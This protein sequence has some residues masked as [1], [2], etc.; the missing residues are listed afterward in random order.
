MS[1]RGEF[2]SKPALAEF[3][4]RYRVRELSVFGSVTRGDDGPESDLDVLVEFES[5]AR[6]GFLL[7]GK[8]SR[9]LSGMAGRR[10]DLVLKAGLKP[11][12]RDHVLREAEVVFAE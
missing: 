8:M 10:V 6:V 9:E 4:K 1:K 3:C 5:D 12:I 2:F 11:A 7:L